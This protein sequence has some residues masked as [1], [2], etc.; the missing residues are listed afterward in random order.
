MSSGPPRRMGVRHHKLRAPRSHGLTV[1][2]DEMWARLSAAITQIQ[3]HNISQLSY[4][5][6]Y[7]YAYNLILNQQ[8]DML[9][10]GVRRQ[11]AEHLARQ[12]DARLVPLFPVEADQVRVAAAAL[13][14][15]RAAPGLAHALGL[16]P[17]GDA[18]LLHT[19]GAGERFL[20]ALTDL[21]DDHGS[22]M[23][24]LRDVL[25]YVDRVYVPNQQRVPIWDLGLDLFRDTVVRSTRQPCYVQLMVTLLRH[26]YCEREGT[27]VERRTLKAVTDM[28]LALSHTPDVSV[29]V[30]DWEPLF[31]RASSEYYVAESQR[32]LATQQATHYLVQAERRLAE[33]EARVVACFSPRTW[34]ALQALVEQRLLTDHL[35]QVLAMPSGGLV[36]L[37]DADARPDLE[38]LYRL[39]ARVEPGLPALHRALR[40]YIAA[41]G[42]R[43]HEAAAPR[44]GS[45][46]PPLEVALAWVEQVLA[47]QAQLDGVL[48]TSLAGDKSCEAA[49]NEA[50]ESLVNMQ[51]R[52]PEFLSL[53]ID[54]HLKKGSRAAA[55]MERVLTQT[56]TLFRFVHEKDVFERYYKLH[57]TRRLLHGRSASDEAERDMIARLKVEGGHSYVQKLQGMLNDMKLSD[58]VLQAFEREQARAPAPRPLPMHVR[59]LTAT[60]WPI[61]LPTQPL[62]LPP[63]LAEA[64]SAFEQFYAARHRGRVLTWQPSL[65]TAD[66][67]VQFRARAHDLSVSTYAL[68]VLLL[69]E[70]TDTLAY[71][72]I[73]AA[74]QMSDADLQ[75]TLQSLACAKYKIL[76][77]EPKGRDVHESDTFT[78]HA[79]FTCPLARIK[80]AQ[81]A[82]KVETPGER[83]ATT[84][85]VEEERKNQVDACIVRIM[86][87]RQTLAHNELVNEVVRQLLPRFQPS[88]ALIKKRIESLLDREYL[89]RTEERH[90]YQYVA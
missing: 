87:S 47:L 23:S 24:K 77:K 17:G 76:R 10:A 88:P 9:Y 66:V 55:D 16:L 69:F 61:A 58:E 25:K 6:H 57:L 50:M 42:R 35:D 33:E 72:A 44:E 83:Q 85:K 34:P 41:R 73:R 7:R 30:H 5:E 43:I 84:A 21:W 3:Q 48:Y 2:V 63:V 70:H 68:I 46:A 54:E 19:V 40:E 64:C 39:F 36:A 67:R 78:F 80:I 29:Y 8:G 22:C 32:L 27:V 86:K 11:V 31:L 12:L 18:S 51:A 60:Y 13:E 38:R 59:V 4:E 45:A 37:L 75:R 90:V 52:A 56:I 74:T 26:V 53:F 79:D 89:E 71:P 20:G 14:L 28:L 62:V 82:A 65:G 1:P 15:P 49:I 81:V